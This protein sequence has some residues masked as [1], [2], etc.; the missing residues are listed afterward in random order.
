M[1][2]IQVALYFVAIVLLFVGAFVRPAQVSLVTL[3][4]AFALL[5][6]ATPAIAAL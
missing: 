6:Y 1:P 2:A 3:G 4:A 5:A